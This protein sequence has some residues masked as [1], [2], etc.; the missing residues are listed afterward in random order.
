MATASLYPRRLE[1]AGPEIRLLEIVSEDGDPGPVR[2]V[3]HTVSLADKPSFYALSYV[4]GDEG[5]TTPILV[6]PASTASSSRGDEITL[7]V[8]VNLEAALR[9]VRAEWAGYTGAPDISSFRLW[10][11]A[12]CINQS[13]LE[14]RQQQVSAMRI[15]FHSARTVLAWLGIQDYGLAFGAIRDIRKEAARLKSRGHDLANSRLDWL[16]A[17]TN[18]TGQQLG[19]KF[20][21]DSFY[22]A[23]WQNIRDLLQASYWGRV[24]ILQEAVL[25]RQLLLITPSSVLS[26]STMSA[27]ARGMYFLCVT[28]NK[29]I[30]E[31]PG[32][33]SCGS[34]R[35]LTDSTV[36]SW[37]SMSSLLNIRNQPW[38]RAETLDAEI[39]TKEPDT[40]IRERWSLSMMSSAN[41]EAK[42]PKDKVY[43]LL[44]ISR[45]EMVPDY[46]EATK[47]GDV[48]LE[49]VRQ[50]V[51]AHRGVMEVRTSYSVAKLDFL[52]L[53]GTGVLD[54]VP[55]TPTW[56]PPFLSRKLVNVMYVMEGRAADEGVF[57]GDN[58]MHLTVDGKRLSALG[59]QLEPVSSKST[60]LGT[61]LRNGQLVQYVAQ[62]ASRHPIS[63]ARNSTPPLQSALWAITHIRKLRDVSRRTVRPLNTLFRHQKPERKAA[64]RRE[65]IRGLAFIAVLALEHESHSATEV[66]EILGWRPDRETLNKWFTRNFFPKLKLK[67][68]GLEEYL[69]TLLGWDGQRKTP[70]MIHTFE[71]LRMKFDAFG[72][73]WCLADLACGSFAF[74]PADVEVGDVVCVM[75]DS[76]VPVVLRSSPAHGP[77]CFVLVGPTFVHGFMEGEAAGYVARGKPTP[78]ILHLV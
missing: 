52:R 11:D 15:I 27:V 43:G 78:E 26:W 55:G 41:L 49:Y 34:W 7:H 36:A 72:E 25:A 58:P 54:R 44:G 60:P 20:H 59:V 17:Y 75:K 73:D 24:W 47:A 74:V 30:A 14:E 76:D 21:D 67:D 18:L 32:W 62:V 23:T 31:R 10:A 4:W 48:Y 61:S 12:I 66:L 71:R 39:S 46:S 29:N 45:V 35:C 68:F 6:T 42:D 69:P 16:K 50:W 77:N 2:C 19:D 9:H 37:N 40:W 64:Q 3:L 57:G 33:L 22:T 5:V 63:T 8:T 13:D 38:S 53:A 70:L 56:T 65:L 28:V 51:L 1:T